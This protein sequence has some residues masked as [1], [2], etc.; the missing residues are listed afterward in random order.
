MLL[1]AILTLHHMPTIHSP[2][3]SWLIT[4]NFNNEC[5]SPVFHF[6]CT[7]WWW[8]MFLTHAGKTSQWQQAVEEVTGWAI[9]L[10]HYVSLTVWQWHGLL[11]A[12]RSDHR[13]CTPH[14]VKP[15]IIVYYLCEIALNHTLSRKFKK[16][17][18]FSSCIEAKSC[19]K[20]SHTKRP[21][22]VWCHL[23]CHKLFFHRSWPI[24]LLL[25]YL[26]LFHINF[27][28]L[29]FLPSNTALRLSATKCYNNPFLLVP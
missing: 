5:Q 11:L 6:D 20:K 23:F 25:S 2:F 22:C 16:W 24:H 19:K 10:Y 12:S 17:C 26:I 1:W 3:P 4:S 9:S 7:V 29:N 27:K 28:I 13:L 15:K 18:K 14:R 21:A 8:F